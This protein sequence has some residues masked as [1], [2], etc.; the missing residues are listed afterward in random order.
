MRKITK[1]LYRATRI[2]NDLG[3]LFSL[4]PSRMGRRLANKAIGRKLVRRLWL[5][6]RR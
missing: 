4:S 6:K 2:S 3:A 1:F 5:R